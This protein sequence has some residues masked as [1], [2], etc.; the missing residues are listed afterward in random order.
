[1]ISAMVL[2]IHLIKHWNRY[3]EKPFCSYQWI[4]D[5]TKSSYKELLILVLILLLDSVV[6]L[7][8]QWH[9]IM[10]HLQKIGSMVLVGLQRHLTM[11]LLVTLVGDTQLTY[12]LV[13]T[14]E[15][16]TGVISPIIF[17][18]A[19]MCQFRPHYLRTSLLFSAILGSEPLMFSYSSK[20]NVAK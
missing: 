9:Q 11:V 20:T 6:L 5:T 19:G 18:K 13:G 16:Y 4:N 12:N 7:G 2:P 3:S 8:L 14:T 10:F 17:I 15:L 1:M